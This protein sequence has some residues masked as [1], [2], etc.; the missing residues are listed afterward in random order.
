[1]LVDPGYLITFLPDQWLLRRYV[2]RVARPASFCSESKSANRRAVPCGGSDVL[3][4]TFFIWVFGWLITERCTVREF[5][6]MKFHARGF[7]QN[8]YGPAHLWSLEY[9]A[10]ILAVFSVA[11]WLRRLFARHVPH[12]APAIVG[13]RLLASPWR[14]LYL[15]IPT[16]LILWAGH[17]VV[18]LDAMMDRLNS[19]VPDRSGCCTMP[20]F[21]WSACDCTACSIV[22][23]DF[24]AY[25]WIYLLYRSRCSLAVHY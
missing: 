17:R 23:T 9:L 12:S 7:Q 25:G 5:L 24:A 13:H 1:M 18:G 2:L 3:P 20:S 14:P 19:F 4:A 6:R 8:L 21:S 16:T 15:A 11:Y 22:W 10:I